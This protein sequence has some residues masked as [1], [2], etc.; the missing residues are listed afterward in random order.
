MAIVIEILKS[1]IF[2]IIQGITE[3]LPI[4]STGHL[5]LLNTLMPLRVYQDAEM[6][7]AFWDMYKVVIQFGSILAVVLL[8][9]NRLN[10][11]ASSKTDIQKKRTFRL[12]M[13]IVAASVPAGIAGVLLDDLIDAKLSTPFV[14]A[15]TLI[16]YGILFMVVKK[17]PE[18]IRVKKLGQ[19]DLLTALKIGCFQALALIPGTSRS[20]STILG[21]TIVGCSRT[22]ATEFSFFMAIPVMLGASV[23]K[24]LKMKITLGVSGVIVL[25]AGMVSAFVI[26]VIVIRSLLG[27]I[28]KHDFKVFGIYRIALGLIILI[29]TFLGVLPAAITG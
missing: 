1:V 29:L 27:Y 16:V 11:F 23:L 8:Y 28:R 14:I 10:P 2:G 5:I 19:M 22:A 15:I 24:L 13:L 12:W 21:S 6:N 9:F 20:G 17:K 26:S 3:W 18:D 25:L 7:M 4:S